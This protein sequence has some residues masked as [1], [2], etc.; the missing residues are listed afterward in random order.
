MELRQGSLHSGYET[1]KNEC[2]SLH[3][4]AETLKQEKAKAEV[5]TIRTRFQDYR[6][7]HWLRDL[8]F[9]LENAMNE[10]R[11]HSAF[12]TPGKAAPSAILFDGSM[13]R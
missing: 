1:L 7:H 12:L 10:F 9:N 13:R 3:G 5:A 2:E 8:H 4:V 11:T 6:V